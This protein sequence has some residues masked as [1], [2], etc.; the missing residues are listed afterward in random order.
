MNQISHGVGS[1][2]TDFSGY[3]SYIKEVLKDQ[4][5]WRCLYEGYMGVDWK[6]T[7]V[8][9]DDDW[10]F[11][12]KVVV[13]CLVNNKSPKQLY[14]V[15]DR[16]LQSD[17]EAGLTLKTLQ[18]KGQKILNEAEKLYNKA[19]NGTEQYRDAEVEIVKQGDL[20]N[21]GEYIVQEYK[22]NSN[23]ELG[24]YDVNLRNFPT[25]T[26]YSK[27]GNIIKVKILKKNIKENING[28]IDI[29]NARVKT[30]P[31]FYA[32]AKNDNYQDYVI[33]ADPYE[34]T[35][36]RTNLKIASN[37]ATL[38]IV[39]TDEKT[40]D[41]LSNIKFNVKYE[42]GENIGDFVTDKNGIITIDNL[43][44]SKVVITELET[45]EKHILDTTKTNATLTFGATTTV[46]IDNERK[47]GNLKIY[48]VDLDNEKLPVSNVE[49]EVTDSDGFKY[50]ATTD[51]KGIAYIEGIRTGMVSI[52][53]VKTNAIYEL[54][55]ETYTA[56]IKWNELTEMTIKNE[57]LKGQI[58][59]LKIDAE[60]KEY[61]LEGVKFQVIN[62]NNE[63]V[64]EITTNA[65]GIATTSRLPIG[66]Y[67][68]KEIAT[69]D[70]HI[71]NEKPI[72][73]TVN[74]D[75]I[76]KNTITNE[77]IKGQIKVIKTT[78][79]DSPI[80]GDKVGTPIPDVE[81][82]VYNANKELVDT[83]ITDKEGIAMTKKL[84]KGLY[85]I[86]ETKS[87]KWYLLNE[88]EFTAE[89]KVNNE[90]VEL[91][92]TNEPEKPSVDI[93][94]TG[95]IQTTA[96]EEIRYDFHIK[97][98][99]NTK[100]DKFTWY[101][102]LPTDYVRITRLI[103]GTY[104]QDLDYAIY[105]KTN[106]N[107]YRLLKDNLNTQVNNYI[108]FS[109][110]ELEEG[111]YVTEFKADF[112]TVDIGFES[113]IDPYIFTTVNSTVQNDDT[114]TNK[115]RIEG[116]NDTFLVWDEDDHTTKVYEKELEVRKLPR[117]GF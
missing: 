105:Y 114:F 12:T 117:T 75:E 54:S 44:P 89:I 34:S 73:V 76:S 111:E 84:D 67:I 41:K 74:T 90:I 56:E 69:D 45:D 46:N 85:T 8:E 93:E 61:K 37:N 11:V 27:S 42:N 49:F 95:L 25:G 40:G 80:T 48:K 52:K 50:K 20:Y 59:V 91:N 28:T 92:I 22:I 23:K 62:S 16:L 1:G 19:K 58:E 106:K 21:S 100:L 66:E 53:E 35:S 43:K 103:T 83:I 79:E 65:E 115:T 2:A 72:I 101:D 18:R 64:E 5:I 77:R 29:A 4:K 51:E 70:M 57:K 14:K 55:N 13:H 116:Y 38:K 102:Y 109:N 71:L 30:C 108:D 6:D 10:Y 104:N 98:T 113:V 88:N 87:G 63:V 97:N 47:V 110:I 99:G 81:F 9:S 68:L 26:T 112:G 96:N 86:K 39:K 15:A 78:S 60:D 24:S 31:A 7:S 94:K 3:D 36:A 32:E 17:K 82:E 107:D 33:A